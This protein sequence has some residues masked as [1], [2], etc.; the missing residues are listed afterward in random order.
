MA[1]FSNIL[2]QV[3]H[4]LNM[5]QTVQHM[6]F[7][8]LFSSMISSQSLMGILNKV[9]FAA[10]ATKKSKL[11]MT[12]LSYNTRYQSC[13]MGT[14]SVCFNLTCVDEV[15]I[16]NSNLWFLIQ[17]MMTQSLKSYANVPASSA[18]S[19]SI[20]LMSS[21]LNLTK[22]ICVAVQWR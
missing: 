4:S 3:L 20:V 7:P 15:L 11:W 14:G 9:N 17:A 2:M 6:R 22:G 10:W 13:M 12:S 16:I 19:V 8:I 21:F 1:A 18:N 5:L